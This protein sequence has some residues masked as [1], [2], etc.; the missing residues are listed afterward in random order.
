MEEQFHKKLE[1]LAGRYETEDGALVLSAS[2]TPGAMTE[3][4]HAIDNTMLPRLLEFS[5]GQAAVSLVAGGR[6]LRAIV[7]VSDDL[8][9]N[10]VTLDTLLSRDD[11]QLP[12]QI[13]ALLTELNSKPGKLTLIRSVD[14]R[15]AKFSDGGLDSPTLAGLWNVALTPPSQLGVMLAGLGAAA[16]AHVEFDGAQIAAQDG[17]NDICDHLASETLRTEIAQMLQD[18]DQK[19]DSGQ[20]TQMLVLPGKLPDDALLC[21]IRTDQTDAFIA[22]A[23]GSVPALAT[24]WHQS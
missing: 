23:G 1:D 24:L 21:V 5:V 8:T 9:A 16:L 10:D 11:E 22:A 14:A 3:I 2:N 19:R 18:I 15:A 13:G 4:L 20:A 7:A 17:E 6:R 12:N